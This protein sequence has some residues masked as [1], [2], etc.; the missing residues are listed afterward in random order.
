MAYR[1]TTR[2]RF[3]LVQLSAPKANPH[4]LAIL[5]TIRDFVLSVIGW[6]A[7]SEPRCST[8][9]HGH[10]GGDENVEAHVKLAPRHQV[11]VGHV[12]LYHVG[13]RAILFGFFPSA[14]RLPFAYLTELGHYEN[15]SEGKV[16]RK[17]WRGR[18]EH[19]RAGEDNFCTNFPSAVVM[20]RTQPD[21]AILLLRGGLATCA[22]CDRRESSRMGSNIPLIQTDKRSCNPTV[23][24]INSGSPRPHTHMGTAS[25]LIILEDSACLNSSPGALVSHTCLASALSVS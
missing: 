20:M 2:P 16:R 4:K 12:A 19:G 6:Y 15:S 7:C 1:D 24:E 14:V 10:V 18:G 13:F 3:A 8:H 25:A 11:R 5:P 23:H 22:T 17:A 21:N 9:R